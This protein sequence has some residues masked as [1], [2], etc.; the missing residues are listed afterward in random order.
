MIPLMDDFNYWIHNIH[1]AIH[2]VIAYD[3][4]CQIRGLHHYRVTH[5]NSVRIMSFPMNSHI[6]AQ[7]EEY[8]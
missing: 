4:V 2:K 1:A 6:S 5:A 8:I 3:V 7:L